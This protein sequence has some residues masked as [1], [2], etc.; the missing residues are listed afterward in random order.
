MKKS[1]KYENSNFSALIAAE[2]STRDIG[3]DSLYFSALCL[4]GRKKETRQGRKRF[5]CLF[6]FIIPFISIISG[7]KKSAKSYTSNM[8]A[9]RIWHGTGIFNGGG[10]FPDTINFSD[11]F[12]IIIIN[13]STIA[14]NE[15]NA[16][17]FTPGNLIDT[18]TYNSQNG[19]TDSYT[20]IDQYNQCCSVLSEVTVTYNHANNSII[21]TG[22]WPNHGGGDY[23]TLYTP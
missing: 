15:N 11:T 7:C 9:V 16:V 5:A 8:G 19:S 23:V 3:G 4:D 6:I 13:G 10:V 21:Y 18:L 17:G 14:I 20:F 1:T 22:F 2:S 12:A